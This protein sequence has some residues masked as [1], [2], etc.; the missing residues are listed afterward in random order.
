MT[1]YE[2]WTWGR[3]DYDL[4]NWFSTLVTVIAVPGILYLYNKSKRQSVPKLNVSFSRGTTKIG[5]RTLSALNIQFENQTNQIV[6]LTGGQFLGYPPKCKI[7]LPPTASGWYPL[8]FAW[9]KT[10]S[11]R[12][13]LPLDDY[14]CILQTA[15]PAN[16]AITSIAANLDE[17]FFSDHPS[18]LR[19]WRLWRPKYFRM[20][21]TAMV[22]DKRYSV[23]TIF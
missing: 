16:M 9:S 7:P 19:K 18:V 17:A 8:K 20:K 4:S 6:Y 11:D 14:D 23:E 22:G 1:S 12:G 13:Q 21:Y 3:G 10:V 15:K 2:F 5:D